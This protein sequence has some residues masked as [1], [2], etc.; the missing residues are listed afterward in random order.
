VKSE[1][2]ELAHDGA[3][4][5]QAENASVNAKQIEVDPKNAP[6]AYES[7]GYGELKRNDLV[8]DGLQNHHVPQ[9][10]PAREIVPSYPQDKSANDAAAIRIPDDEHAQITAAQAKRDTS[11]MTPQ[12]LVADDLRLVQENTKISPEQTKALEDE[13]RKRHGL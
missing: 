13:I 11:N 8:D 3:T 7:G 1:A 10:A 9:K 2:S 4:L 12:Q 6:T 5:K